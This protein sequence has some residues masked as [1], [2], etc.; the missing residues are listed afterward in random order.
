MEEQT[1][2]VDLIVLV[3]ILH[4]ELVT[5]HDMLAE[6]PRKH[7]VENPGSMAE[8]WRDDT[9]LKV[10][11]DTRLYQALVGLGAGREIER[12]IP[13]NSITGNLGDPS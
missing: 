7:Q 9:R 3:V 2:D 6:I 4:E 12:D 5:V 8:N 10:G 11:P 13:G 1:E